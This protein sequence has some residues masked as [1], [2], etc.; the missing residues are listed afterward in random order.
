MTDPGWT[1]AT[2]AE[3]LNRRI[4]DERSLGTAEVQ[5]LRALLQ[6][7]YETQTKA[8]DAA[9]VAAEKAMQTA[10]ASA[11]RAVSKAESA[12]ERRFESVNEFRQT[13]TDQ[14]ATFMPRVEAEQ[15]IEALAEKH[16]ALAARVDRTEGRSTGMSASWGL[17]VGVVLLVGALVAIVV[18]FQP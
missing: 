1:V 3:Y 14:A 10:L 4:D 2:L 12:A 17:L 5:S 16:D 9:F 6:E 13:L 11:E 7:R 18:A 8:L 15:R